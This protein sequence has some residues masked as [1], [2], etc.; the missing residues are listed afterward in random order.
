MASII[1]N[2][3]PEELQNLLDTSN[4]YMDVLRKIGLHNVGGNHNTLKRIVQEYG[5]DI[6]KM[7]ENRSK[8][9]A[10]NAKKTHEMIK[11]DLQDILSGK[12]PYYSS[13]NLAKRLVKEGIK[14][15]KC[16]ICG[17]SE[18]NDKPISLQLDHKDGNHQN[19][20]LENLRLLCPNCHSQTDTYAGKSS[21]RKQEEKDIQMDKP[22]TRKNKNLEKKNSKKEFVPP[23]CREDLKKLIREE[24]FETIGDK[25]GVSGN[26]IKKWCKKYLLPSRK[27]DINSFSNEQWNNI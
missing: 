25:F 14:E 19:N 5:L 17:I 10:R 11:Y 13:Y 8:L 22:K 7:E 27:C 4:G 15:Y 26:A 16:E 1:Y 21:K 18:W 24:P 3:T 12:Y 9:Y 6:S 23:I 2:Y 20:C